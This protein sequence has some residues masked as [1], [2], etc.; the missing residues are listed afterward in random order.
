MY[1]AHLFVS[2]Y[3]ELPQGPVAIPGAGLQ[4][5]TAVFDKGTLGYIAVGTA[6]SSP[7]TILP[8]LDGSYVVDMESRTIGLSSLEPGDMVK[9]LLE[10]FED[11]RRRRFWAKYLVRCARSLTA[12]NCVAEEEWS[13]APEPPLTG[14]LTIAYAY[15]EEIVRMAAGLRPEVYTFVSLGFVYG[16]IYMIEMGINIT[17]KGVESIKLAR[18]SCSDK[19]FIIVMGS[20]NSPI[21]LEA[22]ADKVMDILAEKLV[23]SMN[24]FYIGAASYELPD[25]YAEFLHRYFSQGSGERELRRLLSMFQ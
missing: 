16:D 17:S 23:E 14:V 5:L 18:P 15:E 25:E 9:E 8:A 7:K 1:E 24:L 10:P 19:H 20:P 12:E 3:I 4:F 22:D 2:P 6:E 21:V 13:E 11:G